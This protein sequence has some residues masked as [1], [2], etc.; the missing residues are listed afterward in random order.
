MDFYVY[1]HIDPTT[2]ELLYIGYGSKE[3]AWRC[4]HKGTAF[5][6]VKYTEY[7]DAML[8]S[9]YIPSDWV[10]IIE[11]GL[12]KEEAYN[13][14]QKLIVDLKPRFNVTHGEAQSARATPKE[15]QQMIFE[16]RKQGLS[17]KQIAK[18]T[19]K[20]VMTTIRYSRG[21]KPRYYVG[22]L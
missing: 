15:V 6:S 18:K 4:G 14:E 20:S 8:S 1:K 7:M 13:L 22:G 11:R 9:G 5:R 21:A 12:T 10:I 16:Y 2:L 17:Y 19:G 3:R